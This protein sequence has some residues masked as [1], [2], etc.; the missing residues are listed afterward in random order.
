MKLHA[1]RDEK[2]PVLIAYGILSDGRKVLLS[3]G[4]SDRES[5]D[6]C[7]GFLRDLLERDLRPPR[8]YCSDDGPG[9]RKALKAVWPKSLPQKCQAHKLRNVLGKLPRGAQGELKR[10]IHAV[11]YAKDHETG[12]KKGRSLIEQYR[13]RYEN[14]SSSTAT[15]MRTRCCAWRRAWRSA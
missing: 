1:E 12:V 10:Q 3:V 11:F 9:L 13:D 7:L 15:A 2:Q 4:L 6:A 14:A 8:L 5:Y